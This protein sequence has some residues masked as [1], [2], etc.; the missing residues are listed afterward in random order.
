MKFMKLGTSSDTFHTEEA[1]RTVISDVPNNL[2]VQ[3]GNVTFLLH[4]FP[5]VRKCGLLQ[6]LC[7]EIDDSNKDSVELHDFP[8]GEDMFEVCAKFCYGI[9]INL[10]AHGF[11]PAYCAAKF[12]LMTESVYKGNFV[13]K[14][15]AFFSSCILQGWKDSIVT[16][17]T[18]KMLHEW[19]EN[20]GIIRRCTD[21]IV[22]KI[23]TPP[24]KVTW[25]YTYTRPGY[26]KKSHSAPKDWW[27]EDLSDLNIDM[28]RY[29]ITALKSSNMLLPQLIGEALHVYASRWLLSNLNMNMSNTTTRDSSNSKPASS[30][31][32]PKS[33]FESKRDVLETIAS[34]IPSDKESVSIGFL[35][36]LLSLAKLEKASS[37]TK[38]ELTRRAALQLE[39]ATMGDLL[40]PCR[41][42][43]N[44]YY[45]D[46][47]LVGEVIESFIQAQKRRKTEDARSII[48][49]GELM[50][51]YLQVVAKDPNTP[52]FKFAALA[53]ALSGAARPHHDNLYKAIDI[54]LKEHPD[55]SKTQKKHLCQVLNC[56]KLSPE[57]CVH[58][59]RNE[60]LPLR[61][62]VQVLFFNQESG[63][64]HQ[65]SSTQDN[66]V[67]LEMGT[68]KSNPEEASGG[69]G[70]T[71]GRAAQA[72]TNPYPQETRKEYKEDA[73]LTRHVKKTIVSKKGREI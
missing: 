40:L 18:T 47:E 28:F 24:S 58:A 62:V 21:S 25:S 61:T 63:P 13:Q 15:E 36:R 41:S 6:Q 32:L 35:L 66:I 49:V 64:I 7:S 39:D 48:K 54:Y 26:N 30:H 65:P 22:E 29:I 53:K 57:I 19:S 1:T 46:I 34:M 3:I 16:L 73:A 50:D 59:V 69:A 20:L 71:R 9:T 5:L 55:L 68:S 42:P 67:E 45:Y 44:E 72:S 8:G 11:L 37:S 4:K 70:D 60:R 23:L 43:T 14:L 31:Q 12:L 33:S 17:S 10:S 38:A 51:S 52:P 56:Q 2:I 27:T